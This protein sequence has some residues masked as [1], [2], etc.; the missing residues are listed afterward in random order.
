MTGLD[1]KTAF[2]QAKT[3]G[4]RMELYYG[5]PAG[6]LKLRRRVIF[7]GKPGVITGLARDG[8]MTVHV[9]LDGE[10]RSVPCHPTWRMDYGHGEVAR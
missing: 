3:P 6:T 2:G 1:Y 5:L 9:K 10:K 8:G 7:D 4:E